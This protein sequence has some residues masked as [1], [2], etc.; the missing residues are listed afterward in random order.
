[1]EIALLGA[2]TILTGGVLIGIF[3]TKTAGFG[4][5]TTSLVLLV[6][7]LYVAA[8]LAL[9]GR[10]EQ[11]HLANVLFAIAGFAGGLIV[12]NSNA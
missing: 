3:R 1:M 4:R 7:V 2:V 8:A 12:S 9:D 6:L 10:L 5:Y 11:Q